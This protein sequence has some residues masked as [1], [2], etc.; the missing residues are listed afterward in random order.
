VCVCGGGGTLDNNRVDV[1]PDCAHSNAIT[2]FC[3]SQLK[4]TGTGFFASLKQPQSACVPRA[5]SSRT[6]A[7][8]KTKEAISHPI[9][10]QLI[11]RNVLVTLQH[12]GHVFR[13]SRE[14]GVCVRACVRVRVC[15][16]AC[17]C[18]C[19]CVCV[20]V[21]ACVRV[22]SPSAAT[23][24]RTRSDSIPADSRQW[25]SIPAAAARRPALERLTS[26]PASVLR[27]ARPAPR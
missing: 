17:V 23:A 13:C 21:R 2:A 1:I 26:R 24:H 19:V 16:R 9:C 8:Y 4:E 12:I 5:P 15:V 14:L 11:T 27:A 25:A 7:D 20:C 18:A 6:C 10:S 22:C 3:M